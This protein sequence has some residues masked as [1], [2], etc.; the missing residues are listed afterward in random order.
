M[1]GHRCAMSLPFDAST[2]YLLETRLADWLPLSG[3][4]TTAPVEIVNS[5]LSTVTAAADRVLR[6]QEKP[7]WLL[8]VELQT[9]RDLGLPVS[10]HVYNALLERQHLMLVRSL[11]VLLRREADFSQLTG[12][13]E[14]QFPNEPAYLTFRYQV[15]RV[16]DLPVEMFLHG[17]LGILPLAPL[18][19]IS[20]AMLPSVIARM[21]ERFRQEAT[22][23]EADHLWTA[24]EVLMGLRYSDTFV[25]QVLGG[26][27]HMEDSV[28]YQAIVRKGKISG[29]QEMLLR[30]GRKRLGPPAEAAEANIKAIKDVER[31]E[32]LAERLLDATSWEELL[33]P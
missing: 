7:P 9:G 3:R 28:T 18:S 2:K 27:Y 6:V 20:E 1:K 10:I 29:L 23:V 33:G 26:I 25:E 30:L 5:D 32:T 22:D 4:I 17:G 19:K 24:T 21:D 16:W 12:V 8:H 11:V 13:L 31:L 15:V 14:R